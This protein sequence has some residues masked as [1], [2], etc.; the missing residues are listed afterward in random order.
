V[1]AREC[2]LVCVCVCLYV[3]GAG[4]EGGSGGMVGLVLACMGLSLQVY[5]HVWVCVGIRD[6]GV[7]VFVCGYGV[8][9]SCIIILDAREWFAIH[10]RSI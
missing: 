7:V 6:D 3:W 5:G 9:S 1:G 4:G 8:V 2:V 10:G